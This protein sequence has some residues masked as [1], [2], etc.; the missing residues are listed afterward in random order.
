MSVATQQRP[1]GSLTGDDGAKPPGQPQPSGPARA[2][3]AVIKALPAG[4]RLTDSALGLRARRVLRQAPLLREPGRFALA[5]ILELDGIHP[6]R[7]RGSGMRVWIRHPVDSWTFGDIFVKRV[8]ELPEEVLGALP[9]DPVLL[10]LGANVGLFGVFALG[11]LPSARIVGYEPDPANSRVLELTLARELQEGR[12]RLVRTAVGTSD[13]IARFALGLG[14]HSHQSDDGVPVPIQDVLP[15]MQTADLVKLD[16]EGGEW[17]ML[18][19]ARLRERGPRA[20]VLEYHS[21]GCPGEDPGATAQ[22][23]LSSAGYRIVAGAAAS[24]GGLGG[25]D[26][27]MAPRSGEPGT[28]WAIRM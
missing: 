13:G 3:Y 26:Q 15:M 17:P 20:I 11:R 16:I 18:S 10:D 5:G 1:A 19:D 22:A 24:G 12:Y 7:L 8:Y 4:R 27:E 14:D 9:P 6:Y 2:I 28:L 21:D 23:L 25:G